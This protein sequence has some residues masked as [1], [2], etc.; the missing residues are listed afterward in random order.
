MRYGLLGLF[1]RV[2]LVF[3]FLAVWEVLVRGLDVPAFILPP[4]KIGRAHV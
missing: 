2:L 3:V 4:P 1:L